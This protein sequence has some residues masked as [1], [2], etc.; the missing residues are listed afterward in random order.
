[1]QQVERGLVD[2]DEDISRILPELKNVDLCIADPESEDGFRLEKAKGF[3]TLRQ[4]LTHTSGVGYAW[5]NPTLQLWR[6]KHG[7]PADELRGKVLATYNTPLLFEPGQNWQYG[8]GLDWA[9]IMIERLNDIS[10]GDY[11]EKEIFKPL[12]MNSTTFHIDRRPDIKERLVPY[13]VRQEDGSLASSEAPI[14]AESVEEHSGGGGLWSSPP[15]YIKVLADMIAPTPILLT[16]SSIIDHLAAPQLS[17]DSPSLAT[18]AG[19]RGGAVAANANPVDVGI[20]YGLGGM[21]LT[22]ASEFLPKGTCSWG[23]LPN[24]KWFFNREKGVAGFY[25]S[26]VMPSGDKAAGALSGQ[27]WKEAIRLHEER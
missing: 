11:F 9:G 25:A 5:I 8:G 24:L 16:A 3:V 7:P 4:L 6:K 27:F 19:A 13:A 21:V 10:L 26:Q 18:L 17:A 20:N 12:G 23:G 22:K 2:L 1:M 14:F 15:D